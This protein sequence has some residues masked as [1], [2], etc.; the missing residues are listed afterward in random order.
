MQHR[1]FYM[2]TDTQYFYIVDSVTLSSTRVSSVLSYAESVQTI[3]VIRG[4]KLLG[5]PSC[6]IINLL[7]TP[8]Y[9]GPAMRV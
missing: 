3:S 9:F 8:S 4:S 1:A 2:K 5:Y 6:Q 7:G